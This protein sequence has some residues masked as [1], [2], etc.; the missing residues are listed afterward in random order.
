[1]WDNASRKRFSV[2]DLAGATGG[3]LSHG[4]GVR[5]VVSQVEEGSS[6]D[7]V[8]VVEADGGGEDLGVGAQQGA[9]PPTL[10]LDPAA[11]NVPT[12]NSRENFLKAEASWD[13]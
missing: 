2:L 4:G 8:A 5:H 11:V 6:A 12:T 9:L 3:A 7:Q 10:T 1:M 13:L